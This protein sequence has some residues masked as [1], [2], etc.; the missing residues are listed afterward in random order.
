MRIH[1][2][3]V[4]ERRFKHQSLAL[5]CGAWSVER[6][7]YS[8]KSWGRSQSTH[9]P[10][11][12]SAFTLIEL[13]ISAALMAMILTAAYLCLSAALA[14]QKLLEP[15]ADVAQNARVALE[16]IAADL[17]A[18]CPL[19]K[20]FEFLGMHRMIDEME[21]D[22]LD[23]ATHHYKPR[24]AREADFCEM[25]Y[26]AEKQVGSADVTLYRRRNP[27]IAPDPL[28][29]GSRELIARGLRGVSFEF[30][31][32]WDWYDS[33]GE[34]NGDPKEKKKSLLAANLKGMPE[35][36][37][38]TLRF[39]PDPRAGKARAEIRDRNIQDENAEPPMVFQTTIRLN[40][41][42][43]SQSGFSRDSTNTVSETGATSATQ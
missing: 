16:L 18:A 21:A 3:E 41:A 9:I 7:A 12:P 26:Y 40:L 14:G 32:G 1:A 27:T 30:Y 5:E 15:R 24:R 35:A 28:S 23:F 10:T 38:V 20:D 11:V 34:L 39:N 25:S 8:Y 2:P 17:R 33:W 37:R 6:G 22:N 4:N 31:D 19:S 43:G 42:A 13:V 29:G 36:V